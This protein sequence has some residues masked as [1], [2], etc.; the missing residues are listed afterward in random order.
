[1]LKILL[2]SAI[3]SAAPE[4][5]AHVHGQGSMDIAFDGNI[6]KLHLEV[7]GESLFDFEHQAK[8]KKDI[9]KKDAALRKLE[10]K[11]SEMVVFDPALNCKIAKD[12]FE[13][14]QETQHSDVDAEFSVNCDK[15]VLGSSVSFNFQKTFSKFKKIKVNILVDSVQKTTQVTKNGERVE[16]K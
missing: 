4:Q 12:I 10:E 6:G 15:S 16:L 7:P 11:I 1:M 9:Q 2:L 8:S 13:V 3:V 14:N 5:T